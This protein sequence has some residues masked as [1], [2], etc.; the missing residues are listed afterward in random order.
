VAN[1]FVHVELNTGDLPKAKAFY[2]SLFGWKLDDMP[3]PGGG[4][5][6]TLI[7]VGQGTGGGMVSMLPPGTPPHW[8]AYVGVDDVAE[9]TKR[10]KELGAT[11]LHDVMKVGDFGAMSVIQDPTGAVIAMW[12]GMGQ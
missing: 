6:Y 3:M 1:P 9:M 7:G 4:G 12:Q 2:G 8:L 11:V 5:T 10:A